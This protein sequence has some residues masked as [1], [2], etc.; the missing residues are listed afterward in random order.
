MTIK[1][2]VTAPIDLILEK[3]LYIV[4]CLKFPEFLNSQFSFRLK[5]I[6]SY[7]FQKTTNFVV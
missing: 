7:V 2:N 5:F 6:F 1:Q 4:F 3:A